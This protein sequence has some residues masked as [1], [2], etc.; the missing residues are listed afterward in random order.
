VSDPRI[1]R[2]LAAV[3]FL[4][5]LASSAGL[6]SAN[7]GSHYAL[8]RAMAEQRSFVIDAYVAFT[9]GIDIARSD[10]HAYSNKS[11]LTAALTLPFYVAGRA[12]SSG[13]SWPAYPVGHDA[14][15]P[16]VV[17]VLLLPALAGAAAVALVYRLAR[18]LGASV[19]GGL[20]AASVAGFGTLLW[21][22]ATTLYSH[23]P[24]AALLAGLLL[25]VVASSGAAGRGR[26]LLL[27]LLAG[28]ALGIE[29]SNAL[30]V[31]LVGV[32][33]LATGRIRF[34]RA[35]AEA[36]ALALLALGAALP[37]AFLAA[38]NAVCFGSP[39]TAAY[40]HAT[41]WDG[42]R[43]VIDVG[44]MRL[45]GFTTPLG[46]GLAD[47]L[48]GHDKVEHALLTTSPALALAPLGWLLL[49]RRSWREALLLAGV[50]LAI[51]LPMAGFRAYWG[52]SV[53]DTRYLVAA[54]PLLAVPVATV[55]DAGRSWVRR[56]LR[57]VVVVLLA[58]S[59]VRTMGAVA[60]FEGHPLR[61]LR[62]PTSTW[63]LRADAAALFP[64]ATAFFP[65]LPEDEG[66]EATGSFVRWEWSEDG[67]SWSVATPPRS[68]RG[69]LLQRA[70]FRAN[71]RM[72]PAR[73]ALVGQGCLASVSINKVTRLRRS[74]AGSATPAWEP[75]RLTGLVWPGLNLLEV[76][77]LGKADLDAAEL[78]P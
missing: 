65:R 17:F 75:L 68:A 11:P 3:A 38:Y 37:L 24:S 28:L 66:A 55:F 14:G 1:A 63:Q 7:P 51:C 48:L 52:G 64:A 21:R 70:F 60:G 6:P 19:G 32:Y 30:A 18:R 5:Y 13:F 73:L 59:V 10:G 45:P 16:A 42:G 9:H 40:A 8:V 57:V 62:A 78:G 36:A 23:A 41:S 34:P 43:D 54:L 33:A 4:A 56:L 72:L 44:R 58:A 69:R 39:L 77:V 22:Y 20:A 25:A 2:R 27:G 29:Y 71:P 61:E 74:C 12:W 50:P 31:G 53:A 35:P 67:L 26:A 46:Q 15:E 49:A 76:E 47:L